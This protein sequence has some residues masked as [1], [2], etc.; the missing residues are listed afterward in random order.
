LSLHSRYARNF[1]PRVHALSLPVSG[2]S[3]LPPFI[4]IG[5]RSALDSPYISDSG[6][7]FVTNDANDFVPD[8]VRWI[9]TDVAVGVEMSLPV[10]WHHA[11][12]QHRLRPHNRCKDTLLLPTCAK[13]T[14]AFQFVAKGCE[15]K[16]KGDTVT[17]IDQEK[18]PV[19]CGK[20]FMDCTTFTVNPSVVYV[21]HSLPPDMQ[22]AA[23]FCLPVSKNIS[24]KSVDFSAP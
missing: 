11:R 20:E 15:L 5:K 14:P 3:V 24:A 13:E 7:R 19:L 18:Q 6:N 2:A 10:H 21:A 8:S 23:L 4:S 17:L 9:E 16:Y 1:V 12:P 22:S